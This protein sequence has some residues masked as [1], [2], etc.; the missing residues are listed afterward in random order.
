MGVNNKKKT[1]KGNQHYEKNVIFDKPKSIYNEQVDLSKFTEMLKSLGLTKF[2]G[3]IDDIKEIKTQLDEMK[4]FMSE[5]LVVDLN[6]PIS[7][8]YHL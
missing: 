6:P 3:I 4:S 1:E 8:F 5:K 2:E 7:E